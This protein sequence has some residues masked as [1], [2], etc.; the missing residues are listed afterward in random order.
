MTASEASKNVTADGSLH[1]KRFEFHSDAER[2]R[3]L[4]EAFD[5]RGDVTLRFAEA[6]PVSGYIFN[7]DWE[8]SEPFIEI[9]PKGETDVRRIDIARITAIEFSGTDTAAGKSWD[10]WLKKV[11]E[12]EANGMI[13]ELYPEMHDD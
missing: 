2:R 13:A 10:V 12:A 11:A 9:Y 1:Q 7:R 5:Y 6:E 8:A 3:W 4:E